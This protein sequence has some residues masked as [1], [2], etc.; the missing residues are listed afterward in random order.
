MLLVIFGAGASYDSVPARSLAFSKFGTLPDRPPLAHQL[1]D[2]RPQFVED[3]DLFPQCKRI[4]SD[5]RK[6]NL[7]SAFEQTLQRFQEEGQNYPVRFQQLAA[8]R[9]YLRRMLWRCEDRWYNEHRGITNHTALLDRLDMWRPAGEP[10]LLVT[11]NYDRIL[12]RALEQFGQTFNEISH[13]IT[14][15]RF[16]VFKLHGSVN[17]GRQVQTQIVTENRDERDIGRELIE[18]AAKLTFMD[19]YRVLSSCDTVNDRARVY[20]P[21]IALPVEQKVSFECPATHVS[22]LQEKLDH[23]TRI[24]TVGWRGTEMVFL[25][26]LKRHLS[27]P[28]PVMVIAKDEKESTEIGDNFHRMDIT[29]SPETYAG[30]FTDY[31]PSRDSEKFLRY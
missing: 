25:E 8:I 12:E 13:Y 5:L 23:V 27:R 20:W 3:L 22:A 24:L 18:K 10:I 21:A 30:G 26:L 7:G 2:D 11:F 28:V 17:W 15:Q 19:E 4:I 1:F 9:F 31:V 14:S 16:Q 29:R 6:D